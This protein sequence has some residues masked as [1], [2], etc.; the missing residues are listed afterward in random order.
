MP[1]SLLRRFLFFSSSFS[2]SALRC[3]ELEDTT[4]G[5][6]ATRSKSSNRE[7]STA[8]T[9]AALDVRVAGRLGVGEDNTSWTSLPTNADIAPTDAV[10]LVPPR[11][12]LLLL[13]LESSFRRRCAVEV[14]AVD[15]ALDSEGKGKKLEWH[16]SHAHT[17]W[18][19]L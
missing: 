19:P 17:V 7:N 3:F 9:P 5:I 2:F 14:L 6:P 8:S 16:K 12:T 13:L 10:T 18:V 15:R 11:L 4:E 1:D